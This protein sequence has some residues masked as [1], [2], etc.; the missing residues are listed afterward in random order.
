MVPNLENKNKFRCWIFA[1]DL[2][3]SDYPQSRSDAKID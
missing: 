1:G 2:L 3:S